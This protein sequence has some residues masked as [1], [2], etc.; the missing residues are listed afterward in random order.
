MA[1]IS[2]LVYEENLSPS[3]VGNYLCGVR[4]VLKGS[5]EDISFLESVAVKAAKAAAIIQ[6]RLTN[7]ANETRT[8]PFTV[9]MILLACDTLLDRALPA[10]HICMVALKVAFVF[11]F[12]RSEYIFEVAT[13]QK[14]AHYI[15]AEDVCFCV[16]AHYVQAH[17]VS[18]DME[19]LLVGVVVTLR[20][21][22]NDAECDGSRIAYSRKPGAIVD[23]STAFDVILD[24]FQWAVRACLQKEDPFFSFRGLGWPAFRLGYS[25]LSA[26]IKKTAMHL[27]LPVTLFKLHSLRIGGASALAAYGVPDSLIQKLGRWKSL[28]FLQYIHLSKGS[29]D[30]AL[31]ILSDTSGFTLSEVRI[32]NTAVELG[33]V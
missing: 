21:A 11:L 19:Q 16:G 26:I 30:R 6:Y 15:T 22:K 23:A 12:R 24:M 5:L 8:L 25:A 28:A 10:D 17:A 14:R 13:A 20:S 18:A 27:Q 9:D 31:V 32:M 3:T 4:H 2:N 1:F 29:F 33:S 7:P